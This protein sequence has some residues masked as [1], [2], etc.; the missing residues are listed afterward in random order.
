M[1]S[2]SIPYLPDLKSVGLEQA[3]EYLEQILRQAGFD[4]HA[5]SHCSA[6][7]ITVNVVA[8]GDPRAIGETLLLHSV[9]YDRHVDA[10]QVVYDC[11]IRS[12]NV[13]L[14]VL[15]QPDDMAP[16]MARVFKGVRV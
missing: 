1:K 3:A 15:P 10:D 6:Q 4:A 11:S 14:R 12:Y 8:H 7:H 9:F 2:L 5:V 16:I 13:T